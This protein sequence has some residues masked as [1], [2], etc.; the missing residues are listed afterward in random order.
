MRENSSK[1]HLATGRALH[2]L[3]G[4]SSRRGTCLERTHL[5][6]L[7]NTRTLVSFK[8]FLILPEGKQNSPLPQKNPDKNQMNDIFNKSRLRI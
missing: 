8:S 5:S 4:A 3:G 2:T 6:A 1:G 7:Q